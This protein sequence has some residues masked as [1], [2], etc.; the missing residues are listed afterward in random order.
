MAMNFCL[1][2][3]TKFEPDARFCQECG[4]DKSTITTTAE[5]IP[6]S[7]SI[8]PV[9]VTSPLPPQNPEIHPKAPEP[10]R[11]S[12]KNTQ[13]AKIS[14]SPKQQKRKSGWI[15]VLLILGILGVAGWFVYPMFL[16]SGNK[17]P[18]EIASNIIISESSK[19]V[20]L[21]DQELAKQKA[22]VQSQDKTQNE[23]NQNEIDTDEVSENDI[24]SKVLLEV[25]RKEEPKHKNPKNPTEL[26]LYKPSMITRIITDHY[27]DGMGT[28]R[29][30]IIKIKDDSDNEIGSYKA[31]GKTGKNGTPSAK[32]IAE[33]NIMLKKGTY[34]ISDSEQSTWSKTFVGGNGFIVVEGYEIE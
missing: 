9:I 21:M 3:G 29:G 27:N 10:V 6:E 20:S 2:C 1:H 31:F 25:G 14:E 26:T 15:W 24:T 23:I 8:P 4:F 30:G 33:P 12:S 22:K 11:F 7:A 16:N 32:W 5:L 19:P 18:E 13:S 28:P 17:S 34:Y